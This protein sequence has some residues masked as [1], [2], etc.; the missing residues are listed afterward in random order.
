[1]QIDAALIELKPQIEAALAR[2]YSKEEIL[3]FLE[4]QGVCV[5]WRS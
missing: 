4:K 1:M 2:G 3:V 5:F